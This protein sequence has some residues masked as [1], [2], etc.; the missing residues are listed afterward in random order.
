[1]PHIQPTSLPDL[2]STLDLELGD[3]LSSTAL[4]RLNPQVLCDLER[5]IHDLFAKAADT[6]FASFLFYLLEH[7][8]FEQ[9]VIQAKREQSTHRLHVHERRKVTLTLLAG[10]LVTLRVRALRA[11]GP[12]PGRPCTPSKRGKAK[13]HQATP[14]LQVL[15]GVHRRTPAATLEILEATTTLESYDKARVCLARSGLKLSKS[16]LHKDVE[17][18]GEMAYQAHEAWLDDPE[19]DGP[20][21]GL[22][23]A[24]RRMVL[25]FDGG[26]LRERVKKRGRKRKSGHSGFHA[27]WVEPRELVIYAIN[28]KG[29]LDPSFGKIVLGSLDKP[30]KLFKRITKL[31]KVLKMSEASGVVVTA[32]GQHWQWTR[33]VK[34]LGQAGVDQEKSTEVLDL[35]HALGRL[36]ELSH[37]PKSWGQAVRVRWYLKGKALLKEGKIE[38]LEEMCAALAK[39]RRAKAARSLAGYFKEHRERMRYAAFRA[40][41]LPCGS[42]MVESMIRQVI[43]LRIKSCGKFWKREQAERMMLLRGWQVTGRLEALWMFTLRRR[44]D[45]WYNALNK[46]S[47]AYQE[48]A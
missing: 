12:K 2:L 43:N 1:M 45:W 30:N 47:C 5:S 44:I 29:K 37:L 28:E 42:G 41:K 14:V 35:G 40:Q 3:L 48:A 15:G 38:E 6:F 23:A 7:T 26:R 24:G 39:G 13:A 20:L 8:D 33:L 17:V 36:S 18:M 34:A 22:S 16:S 4:D 9:R 32:D 25:G 46:P 21:E 27:N 19:K 31:F 10:H 11:R